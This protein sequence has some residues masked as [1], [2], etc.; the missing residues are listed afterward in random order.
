MQEVPLNKLVLITALAAATWAQAP[1]PT[2]TTLKVG[3][4]A[5]EFTMPSTSG[6]NVSLADFHGKK[7][8]VLAFFPA[9]FTGGCTKEMQTY[10]LGIEKF[11]N[12][13]AVVFGVNTDNLPLPVCDEAGV[14]V[15][16]SERF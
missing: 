8:V 14:D 13:D 11:N 1:K 9:A 4:A 15:S 16:D 6:G 5:P 3:D 10:G 7:T 12:S 2:S